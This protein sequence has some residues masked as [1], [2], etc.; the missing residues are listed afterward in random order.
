MFARRFIQKAVTV[1]LLLPVIAAADCFTESV[2]AN[3]SLTEIKETSNLQR[4][5]E[6]KGSQ[7]ICTVRFRAKINN[8]WYDARGESQ[9][10]ITDSTDQICSQA[11][12]VGRVTILEQVE[13]ISIQSSQTVFCSDFTN[14]RPK[15]GLK[16]LETFKVHELTPYPDAENFKHKG[17]TCRLFLETDIDP[18]TN[19]LMQWIITGC[20]VRNEWTVVEKF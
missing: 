6:T 14:P 5:V 17:T 18:K 11:Q 10:L 19:K 13:G 15:K 12:N 2:T 3:K 9:G 20:I 4:S 8:K 1:T 7:Q 16:P